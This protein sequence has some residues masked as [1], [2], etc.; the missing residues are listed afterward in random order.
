VEGNKRR[1]LVGIDAKF[2]D[3]LVRVLGSWYQPIITLFA[4]K[5]MLG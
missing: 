2:L 4:K 1:V 3:K 5:G